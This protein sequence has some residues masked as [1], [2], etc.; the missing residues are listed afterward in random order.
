MSYFCGTGFSRV[1][2]AKA[3]NFKQLVDRYLTVPLPLPIARDAFFAL[4]KAGR[5]E[6]KKSP[7]LTAAE[8]K[9]SPARR[10]TEEALKCSLLFLDLDDAKTARQV[11]NNPQV[12]QRQLEGFSFAI[13]HTASSTD[14]DP[15]LRIVI[16]AD[17]PLDR[18]TEAV[19]TVQTLLGLPVVDRVSK[20]WVQAMYRPVVF[21]DADAESTS[22]LI[23]AITN[24]GKFTVED[25]IDVEDPIGTISK[26]DNDDDTVEPIELLDYLR[27]PVDNGT[28]ELAHELLEHLNPDMGYPEWLEVAAGLKHQFAGTADEDKA[29]A[30]FDSWSSKGGKYEGDDDTKAKWVSLRPSPKGRLP[31]TFRSIMHKASLSGWDGSNA[32]R[33]AFEKVRAWINAATDVTALLVGA[34]SRVAAAPLLSRAEEEIL[35]S[36]IS[37]RAKKLDAT[38]NVAALRRDLRKVRARLDEKPEGEKTI[39]P[40]W[41]RGVCYVSST[42]EFYRQSTGEKLKLPSWDNTYGRRLLPT[43]KQ[44]E[45]AGIPVNQRTLSQPFVLP[46]QFALNVVQVPTVW[47]YVYDPANPKETVVVQKG[48]AY[49]NTYRRTHPAKD[50]DAAEECRLSFTNHLSNLIIEP[51]YQ[52]TIL[53]WL[54]FCVQ[55]PG[56]KIRWSPLIQGAEGCGKTYLCAVLAAALGKE[57]VTIIDGKDLFKGWNEWAT[58]KQ[59]VAVEEVR[60]VGHSRHE[61]MNALKPLI[62][63][64]VVSI[65][66]RF[67]NNRNVD[68]ITNYIFFTNFKDALALDDGS[69]RY[70]VLQSA[71]Q[72]R[73]QVTAL[74][75]PAYFTPLYDLVRDKPGGF[76]AFL[77]AHRVSDNFAP[78]GVAPHTAYLD[79]LVEASANETTAAVRRLIKEQDH[80]LVTPKLVSTKTLLAMLELEGIR[81]LSAQH[82][83]SILR[84]EGFNQAGRFL[85]DGERQ[86]LW[87]HASAGPV[88]AAQIAKD[89]TERFNQIDDAV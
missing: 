85:I 74:G 77:E 8:F 10:L 86:Y 23:T 37:Q 27:A 31:V 18:H 29:F 49:V 72:T 30:L 17:L 3:E 82:V 40:A 32:K 16:D 35:L 13:Y 64:D 75:G 84:S 38:V 46:R 43:E 39:A 20:V 83:S 80:P 87:T 42:E 21:A 7:Y 55:N 88:D 6:A 66:E 19:Q 51:E 57:H 33:Y 62:T 67:R 2:R 60:V 61:I 76:R 69:R 45:E 9:T 1:E 59:V 78:N 81:R 48:R 12:V 5:D 11:L 89:N 53:D 65:A 22:P 24:S 34:L 14:E 4:D 73:Q 41:V 15:R 56:F 58:G 47:D 26:R 70:F 54:A 68:N 28:I 71:L 44:L 36:H 63:N 50:E 25:I 52:T 79:D